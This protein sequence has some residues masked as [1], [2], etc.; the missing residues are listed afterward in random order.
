MVEPFLFG[1]A[2]PKKIAD[3]RVQRTRQLLQ[4]ALVSLMVEKGYETTTVQDIIDRAN[5]G[6][7][8]FYSHFA[9][10]NT[11][12]TSR[13]D[14]LRAYLSQQQRQASSTGGGRVPALGFSLAMLEHARSHL[15][16][17]RSIVGKQSGA[18]VIQRIHRLVA[19]LVRK[20]LASTGSIKPGE[21]RELVAE[22][23]AGAFMGLMTWWLE[24]GAKHDPLEVDEIYQ[25]LTT[26]GVGRIR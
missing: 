3:R 24:S 12:L 13:L 18:F 11:L 16:L 23:L 4:D 19:D 21:R 25:D 14:D 7:A 1:G 15:P 17:Y 26:E 22:Y 9:D 8:T 20:N 2:M 6:R 5:V 10:K